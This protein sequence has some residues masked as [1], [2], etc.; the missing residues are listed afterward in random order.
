MQ[1]EVE[2]QMDTV[3]AYEMMNQMFVDEGA[4][5]LNF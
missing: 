4:I 5:E 3:E 1:E 2:N